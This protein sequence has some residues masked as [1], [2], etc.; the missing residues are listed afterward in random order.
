MLRDPAANRYAQAAFE[1]GLER[2]ELEA[3]E[4]DLDFLGSALE[5]REA[6][7][8]VA[9]HKITP[10]AKLD[11]LR[12]ATG[13]TSPLPWN[14]VRLLASKGRLALLPQIA[15]RF[16]ALLDEHRGVA[17]AKV[18]TAVAMSA[19]EQRSLEQKLSQLTG[20]R[21]DIQTFEAPEIIGGI[22][23]RIG[24]TLIDGSTRTKLISLKRQL[25][26]SSR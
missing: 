13:E 22:V 10:E 26:G 9:S 5:G 11:F 4:R 21:V 8:F 3:W 12:R 7:D 23:A 19:D 18:L 17:H 25:A 2:N 1:L 6:V 15:E 16:R 24:D 14:L 20:K